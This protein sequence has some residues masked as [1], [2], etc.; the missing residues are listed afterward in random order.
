MVLCCRSP[1]EARFSVAVELPEVRALLEDGPEQPN[2]LGLL[3]GDLTHG[4]STKVMKDCL[5]APG[6]PQVDSERDD[7]SKHTG[8]VEVLQC[9][10]QVWLLQGRDLDRLVV[11]FSRETDLSA[12]EFRIDKVLRL[13][14]QGVILF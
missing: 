3:R 8:D 2:I 6:Y 7:V 9:T 12:G 10:N 1:V 5:V 4:Q 11:S 13:A 14:C